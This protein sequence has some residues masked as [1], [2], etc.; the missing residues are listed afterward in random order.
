MV[1]TSKNNKKFSI[2]SH[3]KFVLVDS[4]ARLGLPSASLH[5]G[6]LGGIELLHGTIRQSTDNSFHHLVDP[7]FQGL[8]I[9]EQRAEFVLSA[10]CQRCLAMLRLQLL[11]S[12]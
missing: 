12:F 3:Q 10:S 2:Y 8:R 9:L 6:L 4:S 5:F 7:L 1:R 11:P